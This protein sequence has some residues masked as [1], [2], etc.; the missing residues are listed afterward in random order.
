MRVRAYAGDGFREHASDFAERIAAQVRSASAV[1]EA[2]FGVRLELESVRE[3][4][5][6]TAAND[7]LAVAIAELVKEDSGRDVDWVVGFVGP[8]QPDDRAHDVLGRAHLFGHHF[9]LREMKSPRLVEWVD[10]SFDEFP[11]EQR[12]AMIERSRVH[13]ETTTFLHEWAHTLGAVHECAAKGIMAKE[14]SVMTSSFSPESARL[15]RLGLEQRDR[16]GKAARQEWVRAYGAEMSRMS[17]A[18]WDCRTLEQDLKRAR[19]M[20]EVA[21]HAF[22]WDEPMADDPDPLRRWLASVHG[23]LGPRLR[24]LSERVRAEDGSPTLQERIA[25]LEVRF[26]AEGEVKDVRMELSGGN[27][28]LDTGAI[29]AVRQAEPFAR[30]PPEFFGP[31]FRGSMTF[32]VRAEL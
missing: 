19:W 16:T 30:P 29:E 10:L 22:G 20:L 6:A 27:A 9:V 5:V 15:V 21:A 8:A 24:A 31:P 26:G 12:A 7:D 13:H 14:Y 18:W 23:A 1:V 32:G 3:W 28:V 25:L 2:D 11:S 4:H 17:S